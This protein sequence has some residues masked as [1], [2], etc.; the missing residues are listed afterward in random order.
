MFYLN[1]SKERFGYIDI[2]LL[3]FNKLLT[4][5]MIDNQ[6]LFYLYEMK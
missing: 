1:G 3:W 4:D 6:T 5:E 2:S